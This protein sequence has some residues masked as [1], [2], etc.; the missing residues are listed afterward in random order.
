MG[1]C[2]I[3]RS[4]KTHPSPNFSLGW[5]FLHPRSQRSDISHPMELYY[6]LLPDVKMNFPLVEP[7]SIGKFLL[8]TFIHISPLG[9]MKPL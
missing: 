7:I 8:S 2:A 6:K 5:H 1:V 3:S 4:K 9:K